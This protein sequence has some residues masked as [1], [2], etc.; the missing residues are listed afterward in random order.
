METAVKRLQEIARDPFPFLKGLKGQKLLIGITPGD[1]PHELIAAAGLHPVTIFGT[2]EPI[3]F[4]GAL[5]PDNT[6]SLAKSCLELVLNYQRD[7]FDGFVVSQLD[8]TTQHLSD[9][10]ERR[11]KGKFFHKFLPPRQLGRPSASEWFK[12]ELKRL[13][14]ALEGFTGRR[15]TEGELWRAIKA[16]NRN[17]RLLSEFYEV[18]R[19]KPYLLGNRLFFDLVKASFY[20]DKEEHSRLM[21]DVLKGL[22]GHE[23]GARQWI[24]VALAGVVVEPMG[25]FDLLDEAGFNVV[26]DN[27]VSCSRYINSLVP[28]EGDPFEALTYAHLRKP[29]FSPIHDSP[30]RMIEDLLCMVKSYGAKGL[31]YVHIQYCESQDFDLPDIKRRMRQEGVPLLVLTTEYQTKHLSLMK[32]RIEA[33][34]EAILE[35]SYEQ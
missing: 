34:K 32:T 21:E 1:V 29:N 19:E 7:L 28:E 8:D 17:R 5:M 31:I 10:W 18:K 22:K 12:K 14:Y 15:L 3:K 24:P 26:C 16:Y 6:C 2:D 23:A 25:I 30:S 11:S 20:M 4:A 13:I 27:L 9:I 33:F 35:G